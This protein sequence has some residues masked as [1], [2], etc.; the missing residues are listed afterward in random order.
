MQFSR[1]LG[2]AAATACIFS[3]TVVAADVTAPQ[4][5]ENFKTYMESFGYTVEAQEAQGS[6]ALTVTD[7][8]MTMDMPEDAGS[9]RVTMPS[10]SFNETGD[11]TVVVTFP[12]VSPITFAVDVPDDEDAEGTFDYIQNGFVMTVS[13]TPGEMVYD[14]RG[15]ELQL[16]LKSLTVEGKPV[17]IGIA[18]MA[19]RDLAG[20]STMAEGNL[21]RSE[22]SMTIGAMDYEIDMDDPE[23]ASGRMQIKGQV[24]ALAF[25]GSAALPQGDYNPE[26]MN[27]MLEAGFDVDGTFRHAGGQTD[28]LFTDG[29]ERVQGQ[30]KSQSGGF[31]VQMGADGLGYSASAN[32]VTVAFTSS[33]VPFPIEMAL[34]ETGFDLKMPV[35]PG[36]EPQ[37]F[38]LAIRLGD[39]TMSDMIWGMFDPAGQ[40]PRTPAT[41]AIDLEGQ[42]RLD[43]PLMDPEAME[44]AEVPGELRTLSIKDLVLR[45][46]GAEL[47]GEGAFTFDNTD[48][49]TFDG[50]PRPEGALNLR[51][52]GGNTL[53]DT[54]VNMGLLPEEQATG[55][56]MMMGLFAVP[57]EGDDTLTS[58]IEVNEAGQVLA[59][60]QRL[61]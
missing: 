49:T 32:D 41:V 37:D 25:E 56:R 48:T 47:T 12:N 1:F 45:L 3:G 26:D 13:G 61:R 42:A 33:D 24:A 4:V 53:L 6:G 7:I 10:I 11:G 38:A 16:V 8:V 28:F 35:T 59:N 36:E 57:G 5:W 55:V 40:L 29:S 52:V 19:M 20:R 22:Q 15:D 34:A 46:A 43:A 58:T 17:D 50:M 30:T 18:R 14:Y 39:F 23:T 51:L 54:L 9:A 21:V 2:G 60:G 31:G 27:A 44:S